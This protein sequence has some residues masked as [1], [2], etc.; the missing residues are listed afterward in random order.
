MTTVITQSNKTVSN[1]VKD[2]EVLLLPPYGRKLTTFLANPTLPLER[3]SCT[4]CDLSCSLCVSS[5]PPHALLSFEVPSH[6][7]EDRL[8]KA[9]FQAARGQLSSPCGTHVTAER[10]SPIVVP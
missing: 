9:H 5:R 2:N 1:E 8:S 7:Q 4:S 10:H 3:S 6:R